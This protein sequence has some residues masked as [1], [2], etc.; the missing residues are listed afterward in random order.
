LQTL[1]EAT[2]VDATASPTFSAITSLA[3]T[4]FDHV[5]VTTVIASI[6]TTAT[7]ASPEQ[8]SHGAAKASHAAIISVTVTSLNSQACACCLWQVGQSDAQKH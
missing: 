2:Q 4:A 7:T 3:S 6:A 1:L 8:G 5:W